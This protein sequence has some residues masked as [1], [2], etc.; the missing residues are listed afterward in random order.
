MIFKVFL[1]CLI[2]S[3]LIFLSLRRTE[4]KQVLVMRIMPVEYIVRPFASS[5]EK[6][7]YIDTILGLCVIDDTNK[8]SE[9]MGD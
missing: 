9:I 2:T 6:N 4:V 8:F 3:I 7:A 5:F 1:L